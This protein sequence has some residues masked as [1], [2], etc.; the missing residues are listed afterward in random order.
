MLRAGLRLAAIQFLRPVWLVIGSH[1]EDR[2]TFGDE[3][4]GEIRFQ[5]ISPA[6]P[7]VVEGHPVDALVRLSDDSDPHDAPG[8]TH[9]IKHLIFRSA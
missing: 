1:L 3:V 5:L 9:A 7:I 2:P 8:K 4:I 6:R